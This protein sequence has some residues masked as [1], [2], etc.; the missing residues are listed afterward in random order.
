MPGPLVPLLAQLLLESAH[1]LLALLMKAN[2]EGREPTLDEVRAAG[3]SNLDR[4]D[5]V[6]AKIK[7][8]P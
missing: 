2:A 1:A 8:R 5:E 6:E 4:I 7:A 3:I